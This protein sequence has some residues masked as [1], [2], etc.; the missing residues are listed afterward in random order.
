MDFEGHGRA[1]SRIENEQARHR[2]DARRKE[3]PDPY[4]LGEIT[5]LERSLTGDFLS[6]EGRVTTRLRVDSLRRLLPPHIEAQLAANAVILEYDVGNALHK[7]PEQEL[8]ALP[9]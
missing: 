9:G 1:G 7:H 6:I 4:H 3:I 5:A 2:H 8:E